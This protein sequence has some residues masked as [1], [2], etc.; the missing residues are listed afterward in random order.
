[1]TD[2]P[3]AAQSSELDGAKGSAQLD[4]E[5]EERRS[6]YAEMSSEM[7]RIYKEQFGRG[8]T[9]SQTRYAGPD[10]LVCTLEESLTPAEK[11]MVRMGEHQRLRDVRLFFQH[12]S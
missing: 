1:M 9:K 10:C 11:S 5:L 7:V 2:S 4:A 8:P 3:S 6:F 12:A